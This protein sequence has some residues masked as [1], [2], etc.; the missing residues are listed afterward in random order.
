MVSSILADVERLMR[1]ALKENLPDV[2]L[3]ELEGNGAVFYMN[4]KNGTEFDW[5][6]NEHFPAF[7]IFYNDK[8][9]LGAVKA[10]LYTDG[11]LAIYVY[12]DRGHSEPVHVERALDVTEQELLSLAVVLRDNADA[13]MIWDADI[14]KIDTECE[15]DARAIGDFVEN[16]DAY[17][18]VIERKLLMG[19][20]VIVSK[21]VRTEGWK[22]G[23]GLR[24][25]PTSERDSGWFFSVGDESDEYINN[26]ANLELWAVQSAVMYDE[27]LR[28]FIDAP[29]GTAIVRV[30]SD[31]FEPDAPGKRIYLERKR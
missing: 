4:G 1:E 10:L 30:S 7:M 22:I 14:R 31:K 16:A 23:Y 26:T 5:Y 28:E 29:Y 8:E 21:K 18:K 27:A 24:D 3:N 19:K 6:V 17:K 11:G 15:P 9:N 13:K 2:G 12:G 25:E 20:T